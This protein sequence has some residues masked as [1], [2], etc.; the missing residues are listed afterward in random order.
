MTRIDAPSNT[1]WLLGRTL[2]K[3]TADLPAVKELQQ[4]YHST[5]LTA[6]EAGTRQ[7]SVVLSQYPPTIPRTVPSGAE[8]IATLNDE[9]NIDPPP[10]IDD[11]ALKA[12]AP[13]GVQVPHP[14][15]EQSLLDDLSDEAPPLPPLAGDPVANAA[16]SAGTAAGRADHR[17]PR[18]ARSAPPAAGPTTAGRCSATGSGATA[19][20]TSAGRSSPATCWAPTP[21]SSRSI[22]SPTRTSTGRPLDGGHRYTIRFAKGGLPP[23]NAFWSLT[24]YDA[25]DF[26]YANPIDRYAIGDRTARAALR[27]RRI[28]DASISSTTRASGAVP[29]SQLAPGAERI[30]PRDPAALPARARPRSTDAGSRRRSTGSGRL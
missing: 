15:P 28:A 13:A 5:P 10:A 11:C 9:M 26:L 27:A 12:M 21:P 3:S 30:V 18:R 14:T 4:Q 29:A 24:M 1:V 19:P 25:S 2:V 20:D 17:A 6:W 7:P 16:L 8:F 23:V 22:R